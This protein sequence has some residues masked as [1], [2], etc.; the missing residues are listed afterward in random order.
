MRRLM[1]YSERTAGGL[2]TTDPMILSPM[3]EFPCSWLPLRRKDLAPAIAS[4]ASL[5]GLRRNA[6]NWPVPRRRALGP[7]EASF[8]NGRLDH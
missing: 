3:P 5:C 8:R 7:L 4:S 1:S 6:T 2:M